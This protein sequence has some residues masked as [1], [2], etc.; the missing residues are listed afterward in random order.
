MTRSLLAASEDRDAGGTRRFVC[1]AGDN[2]LLSVQCLQKLDALLELLHEGIPFNG[3]RRAAAGFRRAPE[4]KVQ[5][6]TPFSDPATGSSLGFLS[7]VPKPV[8]VKS[9]Q[10]QHDPFFRALHKNLHLPCLLWATG[11][12]DMPLLPTSRR[13][14]FSGSDSVKR[15]RMR[16]FPALP[17]C[18]AS[19]LGNNLVGSCLSKCK[20][21]VRLRS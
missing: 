14:P 4:C 15:S 16:H 1:G 6:L 9:G 5:S 2:F 19:R 12:Q 20:R 10:P 13:D 21:G 11:P 7:F 18:A 8:S 3:Q 17:C